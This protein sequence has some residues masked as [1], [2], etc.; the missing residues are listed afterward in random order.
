LNVVLLPASEIADEVGTPKVANVVMLGALC[1][2]TDAFEPA[3]VEATL[4]AV[5]KRKNLVEMN[6]QAF[7]L[8]YEH[9]KNGK[10]A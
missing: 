3:F 1:A 5:V 10:S 6:L 2:A 4:E 9:V 7:R 8:G